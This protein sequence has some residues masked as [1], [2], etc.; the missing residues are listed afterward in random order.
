MTCRSSTGKVEAKPRHLHLQGIIGLSRSHTSEFF[1]SLWLTSGPLLVA[2][3]WS[4]GT[5]QPPAHRLVWCRAVIHQGGPTGLS[6]PACGRRAGGHRPLPLLLAPFPD[7]SV[8]VTNGSHIQ[9]L[10]EGT[11]QIC[12]DEQRL[13]CFPAS[14]P[15]KELP[16]LA[17]ALGLALLGPLW[18]EQL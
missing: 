11:Q 15:S 6:S 9:Q 10:F 1:S 16:W 3:P 2:A 14:S 8:F 4:T 5:G 7:G 12:L 18:N 13:Q 17:C